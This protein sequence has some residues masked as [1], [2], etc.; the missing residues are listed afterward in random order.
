MTGMAAPPDWHDECDVL[1]AGSG[2]GALTGALTAADHGLDTLVAEKTAFYGGTTAYAGSCLWLPGNQAQERAGL[3][4]SAELGKAYFRAVVGDSAP[5]DLQ[6]AYIDNAGPLVAYLEGHPDLRFEHRPFPDYFPEPG[7]FEQ[8]RGIFPVEFPAPDGEDDLLDAVRPAAWQDRLGVPAE[9]GPFTDGRALVARLLSALRAT[10]RALCR[11]H[12]ALTGLITGADGAVLGA[13]LLVSVPGEEPRPLRVR[14][15]RGVLLAAGGF[16]ASAEL[17]RSWQGLPGADWTM[18]APGG[19]TG[20]A[21]LAARAVGADT[22]LLDQSWWCPSVLFPDGSANFTLGLRGGVFV[23]GTGRRFA[24]ESLPYDRMGR[25]MLDAGVGASSDRPVWWVF[26][27]RWGEDLPGIVTV[28]VDRARFAEAGLW[29]TAGSIGD[30]AA[31]IGVDR[32]TLAG[33]VRDFNA[34]AA[35]GVDPDFHRGEDP[36]DLF[37]ADG[38]GPN[39]AL[40]PLEGGPFHAVRLVLGDLGTKGGLRTDT[41]A[42]VLR[43]DGSV[44]P[45]LYAAGNTMASAAGTAYPGPGA[46]IGSAMVFGRLA[47]LAMASGTR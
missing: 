27:G 38:S 33:T 18:G 23:D 4:D 2:G 32:T 39:P 7:R 16:E 10:G 30:L 24:N 43:E 46:P 11:P 28:P 19:N 40:V 45:G 13:E 31:A 35:K 42:R 8:G 17:R 47:A 41:S 44:I 15:R 3:D 12:T 25:A 6:D 20:D 1:V 9:R 36:Y 34:A 21:I 26:D 22:A 5:H 14:A 29:R 37:F